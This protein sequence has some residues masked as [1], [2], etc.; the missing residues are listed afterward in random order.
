MERSETDLSAAQLHSLL[1]IGRA[2][3]SEWRPEAVLHQVLET[4]REVTGA[5]YAAIGVLDAAGGALQ[6]FVTAGIDDELRERIGDLPRGHGILG[7]LIRDPHPLRLARISDHPRSYGF[8]AEHPPM[9]TFLGVPVV[10]RG[11]VF[12]NLYLTE[13][14]SGEK[15]DDRDEQLVILLAD[16]AAIAIDNARSHEREQ[17][18]AVELERALRGMRATVSLNREL[19]GETDL[20]RIFELVTKRGRALAGARGCVLLLEDGSERLR[21]AASAGEC[22]S[23]ESIESA[24]PAPV[25]RALRSGEAARL[26]AATVSGL[27]FAGGTGAIAPLRVRGR[28]LGALVAIGR[29]GD[30]SALDDDELLSLSTF[31]VSAAAAI[32][33]TRQVEEEKRRLSIA[34]SERERSRWAREIHDETLQ[35]LGALR[36][37]Q[38]SALR[39]DDPETMRRALKHASEQAERLIDGLQGLITELRPAALDQLGVA[40][41]IESLVDRIESRSR[42]SIEADI[43]LPVGERGA[44][45]RLDPELESTIY[46]I[47]QESLTNVV[48]HAGA[49]HARVVV[50]ARDARI[51]ITVS[52]D[53]RGF[54]SGARSSEPGPASLGFGLIGLRERAELFGGSVEVANGGGRGT[55]LTADLPLV[56]RA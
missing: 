20:E 53:G 17:S 7:E 30:E 42:L 38:E 56:E 37:I 25:R 23:G 6:R 9:D 14:R 32:D 34:A 19:T 22:G 8:P 11:K 31:A 35:E 4:A 29:V 51:R 5:R 41:A 15:F 54:R 24:N 28:S 12:G 10:I 13:K 43:D 27:G 40:A 18:R 47:V 39:V 46:R 50:E 26:D 36:V 21:L 33:A 44:E 48:K 16:W 1:E 3:I 2:L 45:H 49:E 55:R 52:D